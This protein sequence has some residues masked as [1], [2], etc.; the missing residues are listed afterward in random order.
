MTSLLPCWYGQALCEIQSTPGS[1]ALLEKK[2]G[3]KCKRGQGAH[4]SLLTRVFIAYEAQVRM[5]NVSGKPGP[6]TDVSD[7]FGALFAAVN[8]KLAPFVSK[9]LRDAGYVA[10]ERR[11]TT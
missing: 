8:E 2:Y 6:R 9:K 4:L 3:S 10:C 5:R 7:E 11:K 1:I